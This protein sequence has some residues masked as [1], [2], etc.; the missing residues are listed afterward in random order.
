MGGV[1]RRT[2]FFVSFRFVSFRKPLAKG[3]REGGKRMRVRGRGGGRF[4]QKNKSEPSFSFFP[5][6]ISSLSSFFIL[7][8]QDKVYLVIFLVV[9]IA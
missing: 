3:T 5:F 9:I 1:Y 7:H 6:V 2:F 4:L 8:S